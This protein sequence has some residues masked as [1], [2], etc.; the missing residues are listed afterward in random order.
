MNEPRHPAGGTLH[1]PPA[2]PRDHQAPVPAPVPAPPEP[3]PPNSAQGAPTPAA[4]AT[5]STPVAPDPVPPDPTLVEADEAAARKA[6]NLRRER[7]A[8]AAALV[9]RRQQTREVL[10]LLR[11]RWPALFT[12][13]VPLAV[14]I[15]REIR[16]GL[17]EVARVPAM[18]L[19]RALHYWT[20]APGYLEAVAA[21]QRRRHLDGT[22]AGEPDEAQR[23]YAREVIAQRTARHAARGQRTR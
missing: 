4:A 6:A 12:T 23:R 15:E 22:D 11:A 5:A 1:L 17:G 7:E 19:G 16:A 8:H 21:G 9:R 2:R 14:G 18:R 10:A 13:P 3:T 20:H